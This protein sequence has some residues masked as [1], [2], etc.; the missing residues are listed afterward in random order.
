MSK[1][2][3]K[4][5]KSLQEHRATTSGDLF[6][7]LHPDFKMEG[8]ID[9][10][11]SIMDTKQVCMDSVALNRMDHMWPLLATPGFLESI[12]SDKLFCSESLSAMK[13]AKSSVVKANKA[14]KNKLPSLP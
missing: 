13:V 7:L 3:L 9:I 8:G 4:V 2:S 1:T 10:R 6:M 5:L 12:E 11:Q 14:N